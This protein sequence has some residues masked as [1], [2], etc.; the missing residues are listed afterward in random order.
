M[1]DAP[2]YDDLD[3]IPGECWRLL[4]CG[5][6]ERRTAFHTPALASLGLDGR[7]RLRTVVLRGVEASAGTLRFHC[8]RRSD[9]AA[10]IARDPRVAL[11]VYD[12]P[13]KIQ[14]RVEGWASLHA[15]DALA[16]AAWHASRPM[17]RAVYAVQ[18]ASGAPIPA[19]GAYAS[20]ERAEADSPGR[21][22]FAA[23]VVAAE[24][25]EFLHLARA[26]HRRARFTLAGGVWI[27]GWRV[28]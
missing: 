11:H 18:P 17:S 4:A 22:D 24:T 6:R 26:G 9:K 21:A 13:G 3:A 8:D 28:P 2:S 10:E 20:P 23:V 25:I 12:A 1:S 15:D 19:G 16:D 7:P 14:V 27:G 5:A